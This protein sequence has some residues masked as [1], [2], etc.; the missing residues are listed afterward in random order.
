MVDVGNFVS[1]D[2]MLYSDMFDQIVGTQP[3]TVARPDFR[4]LDTMLDSVGAVY[5]C[6]GVDSLKTIERGS[7]RLFVFPLRP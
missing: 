4:S 6:D 2:M 3:E 5:L 1:Q 7:G